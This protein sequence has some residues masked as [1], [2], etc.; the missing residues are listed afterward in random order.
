MVDKTP[1]GNYKDIERTCNWKRLVGDQPVAPVSTSDAISRFQV[2]FLSQM[3]LNL[4]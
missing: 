3:M 4:Q 2:M 1:Y